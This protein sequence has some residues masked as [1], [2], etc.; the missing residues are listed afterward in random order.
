M[1]DMNYMIA[2]LAMMVEFDITGL[3][4]CL[5]LILAAPPRAAAGEGKV[6]LGTN[7]PSINI[8]VQSADGKPLSH[9]IVVC[10]DLSTNAILIGTDIQGGGTRFPTDVARRVPGR[11]RR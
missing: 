9:A 10:L 6:E 1:I 2:Q 3:I 5:A 8:Q 4:L 11:T 7:A